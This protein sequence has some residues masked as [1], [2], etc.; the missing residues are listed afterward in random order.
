MSKLQ[1]FGGLE[2]GS[3]ESVRERGGNNILKSGT[4]KY[5]M[6]IPGVYLVCRLIEFLMILVF[7]SLNL[8]Y[9]VF[10]DLTEGF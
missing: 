4:G 1:L 5:F 6:R 9:T 7:L 2:F 3:I 10:C 8:P